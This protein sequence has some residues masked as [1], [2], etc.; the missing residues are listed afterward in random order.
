MYQYANGYSC[1]IASDGQTVMLYFRQRCP[2]FD[3]N[4][5][6]C[7]AESEPVASIIIDADMARELGRALCSLADG[8]ES[9]E[10]SA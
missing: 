8:S 10:E 9:E 1:A 4:G 2:K 6:M 3:S 7:E 5:N